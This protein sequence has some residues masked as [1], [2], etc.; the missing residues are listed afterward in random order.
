[1]IWPFKRL[2]AQTLDEAAAKEPM[3]RCGRPADHLNWRLNGVSC[4]MCARIRTDEKLEKD[5][6]RMAEKIAVAVVQKMNALQNI[7]A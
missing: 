2:P 7:G 4:P 1:M 6:N 5:E 3:P